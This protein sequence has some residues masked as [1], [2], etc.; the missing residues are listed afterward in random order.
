MSI[1]EVSLVDSEIILGDPIDQAIQIAAERGT[2]FPNVYSAR[3]IY[4]GSSSPD[5][6]PTSETTRLIAETPDTVALETRVTKADAETG[7]STEVLVSRVVFTCDQINGVKAPGWQ[8]PYLMIGTR[9]FAWSKT[10]TK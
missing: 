5:G 10:P 6:I 9:G 4:D 2:P 8:Q 7:H 3:T 1:H